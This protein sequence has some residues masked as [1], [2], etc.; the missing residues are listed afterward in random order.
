LID[1][2][3]ALMPPSVSDERVVA[4][5]RVGA[6]EVLA[7]HARPDELGG[8]VRMPAAGETVFPRA[9]LAPSAPVAD[10]SADPRL[11]AVTPK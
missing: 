11:I 6:V 4:A 5:L 3:L 9:W 2:A 7:S 10:P 1:V 8:A